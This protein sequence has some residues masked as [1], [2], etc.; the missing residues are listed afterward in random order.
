MG[1]LCLGFIAA[2]PLLIL[3]LSPDLLEDKLHEMCGKAVFTVS[4]LLSR[5]I[6]NSVL[7]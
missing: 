7:L 2:Q 1:K 5:S 4:G 3:L 6:S